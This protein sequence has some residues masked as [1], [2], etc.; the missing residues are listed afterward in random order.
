[1]DVV[2][3]DF[4]RVFCTKIYPQT[5]NFRSNI[6]KVSEEQRNRNKNSQKLK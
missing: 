2:F 6:T 3:K 5:E 4:I 1:M